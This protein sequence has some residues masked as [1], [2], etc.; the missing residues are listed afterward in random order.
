VRKS[1]LVTASKCTKNQLAAR[2]C[3]DLLEE[4]TVLRDSIAGFRGVRRGKGKG[5]SPHSDL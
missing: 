4:L 1:G 3:L 5:R 2:L